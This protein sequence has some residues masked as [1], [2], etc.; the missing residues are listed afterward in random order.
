[1]KAKIISLCV[2]IFLPTFLFAQID[3]VQF[4]KH[5]L[6]KYWTDVKSI[7]VSPTKWD[8]QDWTKF[9]VFTGITASMLFVD[10]PISEGFQTFRIYTGNGGEKFAANVLEPFGAE[11]SLAVMGSFMVYGLLAKDI[12][13]QSTGLLALE[14]F[15]LS[16]AFVRIPKFLAGRSRPDS[17]MDVSAFEFNGFGKGSSFPSGHTIAVFAV[18]SVIANQYSDTK[19]VPVVSYSIA[20]LAGLSRVFDHR[21]WASDVFTSAVLGTLIG[22]LVSKRNKDSRISLVPYYSNSVKGIKLALTL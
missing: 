9:G 12:K 15:L 7:V 16:S 8:G 19:W 10:E 14:S 18:A 21:H 20:G 11:Y 2:L 22:N 1:M 6:K 17:G 5:Y 3:T 4:N 13:S